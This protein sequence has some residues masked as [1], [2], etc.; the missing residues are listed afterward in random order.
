MELA[1]TRNP[2]PSPPSSSSPLRTPQPHTPTPQGSCHQPSLPVIPPLPPRLHH[3]PAE[4][5][6]LLV[7]GVGGW[8][9]A[10]RPPSQPVTGRASPPAGN[11]WLNSTRHRCVTPSADPSE[12]TPPQNAA[13]VRLQNRCANFYDLRQYGRSGETVWLILF[14]LFVFFLFPFLSVFCLSLLSFFRSFFFL[15]S[16]TLLTPLSLFLSPYYSPLSLSLSLTLISLVA[17][18]SIHVLFLILICLTFLASVHRQIL[19]LTLSLLRS[20][21]VILSALSHLSLSSLLSPS[22]SLSLSHRSRSFSVDSFCFILFW[23]YNC[24]PA[25]TLSNGGAPHRGP[26]LLSALSSHPSRL[27]RRSSSSLVLSSLSLSRSPLLSLSLS[28]LLHYPSQP[29][30]PLSLSSSPL[31]FLSPDLLSPLYRRPG[32]SL[33]SL[34]P[35]PLSLHPLLT[36]SRLSSLLLSA[37]FIPHAVNLSLLSPLPPARAPSSSTLSGL[38]QSLSLSLSLSLSSLFHT[39]PS[40]F[41]LSPLSLS[42]IPALPSLSETS[43]SFSSP[44]PSLLFPLIPCLSLRISSLRVFS[45]SSPP[46]S[47]S[48]SLSRLTFSPP[49]GPLSLLSPSV[50]LSLVPRSLSSLVSPLSPL[51]PPTSLPSLS[52]LP[53]SRLPPL[54]L[55]LLP[56]PLSLPPLHLSPSLPLALSCLEPLPLSVYIFLLPLSLSCPPSNKTSYIFLFLSL[57]SLSLPLTPPPECAPQSHGPQIPSTHAHAP[58]HDSMPDF[59]PDSPA[60]SRIIPLSALF[61]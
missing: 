49:V 13:A 6:G 59:V 30:R 11:T 12:R 9:C 52:P 54:P 38:S 8:A 27:S 18:L 33:S 45:S 31:S 51:S 32:S 36:V 1:T 55:S 41:I 48:S 46:R 60:T 21:V 14:F 15:S 28:P 19:S 61:A 37:S 23:S 17:P 16:L 26:L 39:L 43:L 4:D 57:P 40:H 10:R 47:L 35:R 2:P 50:S 25:F 29:H 53:P 44:F 20:L 3:A 24:L 42:P 7:G 22:L 34:T 5:R 58:C 56:L